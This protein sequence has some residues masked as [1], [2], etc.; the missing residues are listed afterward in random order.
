MAKSNPNSSGPPQDQREL[1]W[2]H[3]VLVALLGIA[4]GSHSHII[5]FMHDELEVFLKQGLN[6]T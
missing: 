2:S 3:P 5:G 1:F 6:R 4:Q